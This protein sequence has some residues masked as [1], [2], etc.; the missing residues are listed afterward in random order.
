MV[1]LIWTI[2]VVHYPLFRKVPESG[3]IEYERSHTRRMGTLLALPAL[4]EIVTA[5]ALVRA[6]PDRVGLTLVLI[7]GMLLA[8]VWIMTA[9]VQA[10]IHRRLSAGRD[11]E[12]IARLIST[13]WWRTA[14]WSLRGIAAAA[15]LSA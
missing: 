1:G 11:P 5:A 15:I 8:A 13:D 9:A 3:F 2:Q 4:L 14:L 10:P 12:L 7:A 6:R